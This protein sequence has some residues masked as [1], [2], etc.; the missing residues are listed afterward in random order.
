MITESSVH[1]A[2]APPAADYDAI[3]AVIQLYIDGLEQADEE[4]DGDDVVG[5]GH[6]GKAEGDHCPDKLAAGDPDG[7]TDFGQDYL[8]GHLADDVAA[9]PG[10][11]DHIEL[12]GV[13]C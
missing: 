4:A 11:V 5:R 8:R 3:A 6:G 13:H 9:G 1:N 2:G 7:G 12:V 10:D